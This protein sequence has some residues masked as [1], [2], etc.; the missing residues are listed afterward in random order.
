MM[1]LQWSLWVMTSVSEHN[2]S[3]G[4]LLRW[5]FRAHSRRFCAAL[6]H[7]DSRYA[8]LRLF[9]VHSGFDLEV[10]LW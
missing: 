8:S 9:Q 10:L 5:R 7:A 6:T 2:L 1:Y 3:S 4:H